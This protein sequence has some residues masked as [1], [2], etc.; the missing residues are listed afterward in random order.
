MPGRISGTDRAWGAHSA[1]PLVA[2]AAPRGRNDPDRTTGRPA[3]LVPTPPARRSARRGR[4]PLGRLDLVSGSIPPDTYFHNCAPSLDGLAVLA[5]SHD[6]SIAPSPAWCPRLT[7]TPRLLLSRSSIPAIGGRKQPRDPWVDLQVR[8]WERPM[9]SPQ[10]PCALGEERPPPSAPEP[11][12][13]R[14]GTAPHPSFH[15]PSRP[16]TAGPLSS[17]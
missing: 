17:P 11:P 2:T 15:R 10:H 7:K 5:S 9:A 8:T 1:Y 4:P 16:T 12:G 14:P 3:P 6:T 13:R